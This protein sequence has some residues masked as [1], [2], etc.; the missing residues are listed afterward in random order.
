MGKLDDYYRDCLRVLNVAINIERLYIGL[1]NPIFD[2]KQRE[3]KRKM[4]NI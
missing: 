1:Y 3:E 4:D 2:K